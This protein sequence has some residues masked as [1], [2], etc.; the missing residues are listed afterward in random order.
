MAY[1]IDRYNGTLLVS[2]DDQTINTTAT[3]IRLVGRN[4]AGYGEIQ[5]ENFLHLLENFSNSSPPARPLSGQ[6]WYDSTNKKL[7][8]YDGT[9]F[10]VA[11]G[12]EASANPPA[13]LSVGDFWF[14]TQEE[15]L[16]AWTGV[17]FV[18]VGPDRAPVLGETEAIPA[19]IK[20]VTGSDQSILILQVA[21]KTIGL[22]SNSE[23]TIN[24]VINP[25]EGF[26]SVKKGINLSDFQTTI[27][28]S[29]AYKLWGT[30]VNSEKLN[31]FSSA[32]FLRAENTVF[33]TI[34]GFQDAGFTVGDQ[35]DLKVS[36]ANGN[37]VIIENTLGN[38]LIFRITSGA[39]VRDI[40]L[41]REDGLVP[42]SSD[43]Y[44]LGKPGIRWKEVNSETVRADTFYGTFVGTIETPLGVGGEPVPLAIESTNIAEELTV[45][46]TASSFS[47]N[48]T[49]NSGVID[50]RSGIV[51]TLENFNIGQTTPGTGKFTTLTVTGSSLFSG[52]TTI[53]NSTTI[54][55]TLSITD[56]V[57][58]SGT[59]YIKVPV[60]TEAQRPLA[61]E[62]GM[63][64]FNTTEELFEG[65]T[66]IEWIPLTGEIDLDYGLITSEIDVFVDYGSIL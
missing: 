52:P 45:A 54:A 40:L 9:K 50:L 19:V 63:V 64:R 27:V 39:E 25:I 47:A 26:S 60:G 33:P 5:N 21:G 43:L 37:E 24:S 36:I 15:Q 55:G 16:F 3:D 29:S 7:K 59:G 20:D 61:P 48:F 6:V 51:G 2:I 38:S 14:D 57:I 56:N 22:I 66:G 65:Y 13:G 42:G 4:Y 23:F 12:A 31:G 41:A 58:L 10:K 62:T 28:D 34:V 8:F 46:P 35:K 18:L 11:G 49:G 32:D 17:E 30:A 53:N 44:Y 1:Q